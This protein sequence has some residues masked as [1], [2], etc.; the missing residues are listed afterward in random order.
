MCCRPNGAAPPIRKKLRKLRKAMSPRRTARPSN[1][2]LS[3]SCPGAATIRLQTRKCA[4]PAPLSRYRE[5]DR[6][7]TSPT[8]VQRRIAIAALCCVLG[9]ALIGVRLVDLTLLRA[10]SASAG[11]LRSH[12]M[13]ARADIV[14]RNGELL[15]RD[16]I[17]HDLSVQPFLLPDKP[18]AA[19]ELAI[20]TGTDEQR[21]L[22]E[23]QRHEKPNQFVL[24][25]RQVTPDVQETLTDLGLP[26]LEFDAALRRYYPLGS[27]AADVLGQADADG[28]GVTGV[29]LGLD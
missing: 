23:F 28:T 7:M 27:A 4:R 22:R 12:A 3:R 11:V 1:L 13:N 21:L 18:A 9:F 25:A 14:D 16:L 15:A 20:A 5:T 19:H 10:V 29:E 17:V 24:V 26:G 2:P 8:I 6:V